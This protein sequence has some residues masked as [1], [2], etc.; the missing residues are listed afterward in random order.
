MCLR[1]AMT[2]S[3]KLGGLKKEKLIVSEFGKPEVSN[4]SVDRIMLPPNSVRKL[5]LVYFFLLEVDSN[6][7]CYL[8]CSCITPVSAFMV[9]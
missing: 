2:K 8:P 1:D 3:H 7:W 4:N 6:L 5:F 9:T